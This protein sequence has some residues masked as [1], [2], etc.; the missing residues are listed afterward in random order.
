MLW[1]EQAYI[2][3]PRVIILPL[4]ILQD[5][6]RFRVIGRGK[7]PKDSEFGPP[8]N[9]RRVNPLG[10]FKRAKAALKHRVNLAHAEALLQDKEKN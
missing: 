9:P 10:R 8:T 6:R 4:A 2:A 1:M 5:K 7:S 3:M